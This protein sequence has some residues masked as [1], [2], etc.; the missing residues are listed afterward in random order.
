MQC[1]RLLKGF[2]ASIFPFTLYGQNSSDVFNQEIYSPSRTKCLDL[3]VDLP[4]RNNER[5]RWSGRE[6]ERI[7]INGNKSLPAEVTRTMGWGQRRNVKRRPCAHTLI[8]IVFSTA[9]GGWRVFILYE[10][11]P[12][13]ARDPREIYGRRNVEQWYHLTYV[14]NYGLCTKL[15]A[16][17]FELRSCLFWP[18][19]ISSITVKWI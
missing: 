3:S 10:L 18:Q 4:V 12:F 5:V 6:R 17:E 2:A 19:K 11:W 16:R 15:Y 1:S 7:M 14:F 13:A 9:N 8:F